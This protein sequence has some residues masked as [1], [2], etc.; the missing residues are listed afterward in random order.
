MIPIVR[1]YTAQKNNQP[2]DFIIVG[3][4]SLLRVDAVLPHAG[5]EYTVTFKRKNAGLPDFC[6]SIKI[7]EKM[8]DGSTRYAGSGAV[9]S[10]DPLDLHLP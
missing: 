3:F 5:R 10:F 4:G 1:K 9:S 8:P 7:V 2:V 6:D